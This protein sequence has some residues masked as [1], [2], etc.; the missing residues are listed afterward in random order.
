MKRRILALLILAIVA[1]GAGLA[2]WSLG[3]DGT[4][5]ANGPLVLYGNVDLRQVNLAFNDSGR[6]AA[7]LVD[8]GSKVTAG[9]VL[10]RLDTSRI[11]P[12]VA[13]A[14]AQV[15]AQAAVV[16]KLHNGSRPEE[17]AQAKANVDAAAAA[18]FNAALTYRRLTMIVA[19]S[20]TTAVSQSQMDTAK[21]AQD[22]ADAQLEVARQAL[23]LAQAGPRK[24]DVAQ[25]EAQLS[26]VK[27]QLALL[28][29]QLADTALR[30]PSDGV[31][32][33]R[34]LEPGEMAS[35]S[36]PVFSMAIETPKWVR[37]YVAESDLPRV[38]PGAAATV[39]VDGVAHAFTGH[40]GF[41]SPVAEFTPHTI[42]TAE[43]RTSLV[44][45]VRILVDDP[46]DELRLGMPATVHLMTP[47]ARQTAHR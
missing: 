10:A 6:I 14:Q 22:S 28:K 3:R 8:E 43:L 24:E 1:A 37:A 16:E 27:A 47:A 11:E 29:Q 21:A 42:Q 38:A 40:V 45:E 5:S 46:T 19:N 23:V 2:L 26:A 7:V 34:L 17:I 36:A 39:T 31:I 13:Q 15:E 41:I 25:A 32:R 9:E 20:G 35:P 4:G 33:S 12:Q 30:A 18:A 44:Y